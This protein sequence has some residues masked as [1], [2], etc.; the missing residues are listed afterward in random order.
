[1]YLDIVLSKTFFKGGGER[2]WSC[3]KKFC[4]CTFYD[5]VM[6]VYGVSGNGIFILS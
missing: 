3:D 6:G 5:L 1:M 2:G 4:G